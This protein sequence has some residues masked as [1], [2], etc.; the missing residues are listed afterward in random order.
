[1]CLRA[2]AQLLSKTNLISCLTDVKADGVVIAA[3]VQTT[4]EVRSDIASYD[5][6]IINKIVTLHND[7][8]DRITDKEN[9][10][11]PKVRHY[12]G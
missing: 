11:L 3:S 7:T 9:E 2:A 6:T 4:T 10:Y 1:M 5:A 8:V 12:D